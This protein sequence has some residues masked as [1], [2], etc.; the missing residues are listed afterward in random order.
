MLS[1][2]LWAGISF[3]VTMS[4]VATRGATGAGTEDNTSRDEV[5]GPE[6][7]VFCMAEV[8]ARGY[9]EYKGMTGR[10]ISSTGFF[11][12]PFSTLLTQRI[13]GGSTA[14]PPPPTLRSFLI[15]LSS[16]SFINAFSSAVLCSSVSSA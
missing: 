8:L 7:L 5:L 12:D 3:L 9:R 2:E 13:A 4:V 10:V 16:S 15:L 11:G 1:A 6:E 14:P